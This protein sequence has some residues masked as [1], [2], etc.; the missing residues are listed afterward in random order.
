[1]VRLPYLER[2]LDIGHTMIKVEGTYYGLAP[3]ELGDGL[4]MSHFLH[5]QVESHCRTAARNCRFLSV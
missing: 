3:E 2:G 1:L 5:L 4:Q